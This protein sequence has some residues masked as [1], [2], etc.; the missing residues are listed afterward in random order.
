MDNSGITLHLQLFNTD[1]D[2]TNVGQRWGMWQEEFQ[3]EFHL[4]RATDDNDKI[5]C[6]KGYSER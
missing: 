3:D 1:S 5:I 6:L 4:Q 2:K